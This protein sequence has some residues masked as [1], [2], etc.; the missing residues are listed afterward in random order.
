[1]RNSI[2]LVSACALL[3]LAAV[4]FALLLAPSVELDYGI[5]GYVVLCGPFVA[6]IAAIALFIAY[7]AA[8]G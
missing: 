7:F 4:G 6:A 8:G 2:V 3:A 1:M 5:L